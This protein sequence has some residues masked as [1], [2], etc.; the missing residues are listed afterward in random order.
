MARYGG[1]EFV[2]LLPGTDSAGALE[3]A[4]RVRHEIAGA[5]I[6]FNGTRIDLTVSVGCATVGQNLGELTALMKAADI[7]LYRSK[8]LGR[9]RSSVYQAGDT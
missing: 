7:A 9:N 2:F 8:R 5:S 6:D 3:L 1:E 4:E